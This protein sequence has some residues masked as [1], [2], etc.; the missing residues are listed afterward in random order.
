MSIQIPV[1]RTAEAIITSLRNN[2]YETRRLMLKLPNSEYNQIN[3]FLELLETT[4]LQSDK[5]LT[6]LNYKR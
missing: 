3:N 5:Y 6:T 1:N 2:T 4:V